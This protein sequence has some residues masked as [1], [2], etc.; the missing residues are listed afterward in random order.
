MHEPPS[1]CPSLL[2]SPS[3]TQAASVT[4]LDKIMIAVIHDWRP[5]RKNDNCTAALKFFT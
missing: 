1:R 5:D 4:V 3:H 2:I